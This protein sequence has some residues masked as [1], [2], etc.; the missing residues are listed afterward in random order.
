MLRGAPRMARFILVENHKFMDF[1]NEKINEP[2]DGK[3]VV[4]THHSP[5]NIIKRKGRIDD[6]MDYCYWADLENLIGNNI[7]IDLWVH[8]HSHDTWDYMINET[9]VVCNPYGYHNYRTNG[10]FNKNLILEV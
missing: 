7:T 3:V 4:I 6:L 9:R 1:L 8:G 5:G 2:F 10:R